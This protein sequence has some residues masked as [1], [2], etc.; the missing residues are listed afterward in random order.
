V[1]RKAKPRAA[2]ARKSRRPASPRPCL[3]PPVPAP[4]TVEE[5]LAPLGAEQRQALEQ[6]RRDVQAAA[7]EALEC[8]SY[9]IPT[10]RLEGR[11]LVAFGAAARHCAFYP[12]AFP[13]ETHRDEL[14][15]YD[16]SKGTIRFPASQPLPALLVRK[17]VLA[18]IAEYSTR[19]RMAGPPRRG[20]RGKQRP[21][22]RT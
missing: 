7:P 18:R 5:Y 16:T 19:L 14:L 11:M 2:R 4:R 3:Q 20:R 13:I 12:G 21:A 15:A 17:L 22:R 8:I 10:F 1:K 6:L 9:G